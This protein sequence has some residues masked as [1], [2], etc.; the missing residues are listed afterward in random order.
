MSQYYVV[1][2]SG[3]AGANGI[4]KG[5][6]QV[7]SAWGIRHVGLSWERFICAVSEEVDRWVEEALR[8]WERL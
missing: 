5:K 7:I 8:R 3:G 1:W 4:Y 2:G 6:E